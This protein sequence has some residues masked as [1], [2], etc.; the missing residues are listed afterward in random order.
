MTA[1]PA[2]FVSSRAYGSFFQRSCPGPE[3]IA[4][5]YWSPALARASSVD[6]VPSFSEVSGASVVDH[7]LNVP[8]TATLRA[9]G[10]QTRKVTPPG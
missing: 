4:N 5:L 7:P 9:N 1:L 10:A 6:Q 3:V 8:A 2:S